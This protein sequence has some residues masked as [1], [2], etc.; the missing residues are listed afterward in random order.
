MINNPIVNNTFGICVRGKLSKEDFSGFGQAARDKETG[1][2]QYSIPFNIESIGMR[3]NFLYK[4]LLTYMKT[5]YEEDEM[6]LDI[7]IAG[8]KLITMG[9]TIFENDM[10]YNRY[11]L[12]M[13]HIN[14][15]VPQLQMEVLLEDDERKLVDEY[16]NKLKKKVDWTNISGCAFV[17][18]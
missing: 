16:V 1:E 4:I 9:I 14:H 12:G 8:D 17:A 3:N 18:K 15:P 6:L 10:G 2:I 13:G 7:K 11:I 5:I